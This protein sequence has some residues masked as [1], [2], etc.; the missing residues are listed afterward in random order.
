M[1]AVLFILG[2][3]GIL[4]TILVSFLSTMNLGVALPAILG[5]P[6]VAFGVFLPRLQ[7]AGKAGHAVTI[8]LACGYLLLILLFAVTWVVIDREANKKVYSGADAVIVLGAGLRGDTPTLVLRNR[9]DTAIAYLEEH[10]DAV[11][12]LSGGKGDNEHI[13][14]AEAMARYFEARGIPASRC[15]KEG[16]STSTEENF[17]YSNRIIK[18]R[19][20]ENAELAFVTTDFHIFRASRVAARQGIKAQGIAAPDVWY[21]SLNNHL[22]ECAAVWAYALLGRL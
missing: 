18:G 17:L 9:M 21:L 19:F 16:A 7:N 4:D 1:R 12:I 20:G 10:P 22:R 11:A 6:L 2:A 13:S 3:L 5:L 15:I 8:V 14:E